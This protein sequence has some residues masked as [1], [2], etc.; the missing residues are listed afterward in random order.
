MLGTNYFV[1]IT[2]TLSVAFDDSNGF[3]FIAKCT[4]TPP[5][6][7]FPNQFVGFQHG[8][9]LFQTDSG[10]GNTGWFQNTAAAGTSPVW[11]AVIP[12]GVSAIAYNVVSVLTNAGVPANVFGVTN[13]IN[14][15]VTGVIVASGDT[16]AG[17]VTLSGSNGTI[18]VVAKSTTAGGVTGSA[19]LTASATPF[20]SAGTLTV[21]TSGSGTSNVTITFT[22]K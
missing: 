19:T 6:S 8:C 21:V 22:S 11:E 9:F 20:T 12:D 7:G 3:A 10:A 13:G 18:A 4:G 5:T 15:T 17:N 1:P 16:Q 2:S 14:G